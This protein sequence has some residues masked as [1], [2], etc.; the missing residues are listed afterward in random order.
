MNTYTPVTGG[1]IGDWIIT[2]PAGEIV[3]VISVADGEMTID[4]ILVAA[5]EAACDPDTGDDEHRPPEDFAGAIP[6]G[7]PLA[8]R[9]LA[10]DD[11]FSIVETDTEPAWAEVVGG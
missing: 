7:S 4:G 9:L 6:V 1:T 8:R 5:Y 11:G 3:S 2:T 10:G